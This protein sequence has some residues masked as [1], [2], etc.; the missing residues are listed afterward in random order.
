MT[1]LLPH[2]SMPCA[3]SRLRLAH[4][5]FIAGAHELHVTCGAGQP[6]SFASPAGSAVRALFRG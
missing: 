1:Y 6:A 5:S 3:P 2:A 4:L